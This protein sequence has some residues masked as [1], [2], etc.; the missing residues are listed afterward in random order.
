MSLERADE[1][2]S[3]LSAEYTRA[4]QAKLVSPRAVHYT[5]EVAERLRSVLDRLARCYWEKRVSPNLSVDD[6]SK[7]TVYFPI[8][9]SAQSFGSV[10][11]Q[12]RWKAI[13]ADH[14]ELQ[15][16][17]LSLQPF[18]GPDNAWLQILNTLALQSKHIDLVPQTRVEER[19]ITVIGPSGGSVSWGPG[20][21][22][23]SGVSIMGAPVD[24]L[25]QR[26]LPT[27]GVTEK[28]ETWVSFVIEGHG[29]NAL[30]FSTR[31]CEQVRQIAEAMSGQFGI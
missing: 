3:E 31:A 28:V 8:T 29:V 2:L 1:I 15:N 25:T 19:R 30:T 16:Y 4:L 9:D 17:L 11:G 6:R 21:T 26:I 18:Q 22:F 20:V 13:A 14:E 7:A 10:M 23:G 5:H 12:W 27:A 24:P